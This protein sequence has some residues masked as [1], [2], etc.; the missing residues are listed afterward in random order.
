MFSDDDDAVQPVKSMPGVN[1]YG[2]NRVR[3]HLSE[4][5]PK[6][7]SSVL[8]FGVTDRLFKVKPFHCGYV[9]DNL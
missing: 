1:R 8:L 9:L 5:V 7:L 3:E 4:I 6:G 2:I